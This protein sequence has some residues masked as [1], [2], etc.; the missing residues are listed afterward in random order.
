MNVKWQ[1]KIRD[2]SILDKAGIP[3]I[4]NILMKTQIRWAGHVVRMPGHRLPRLLLYCQIKEGK[5]SQGGQKKRYKDKRK[6][7]LKAFCIKQ[8]TWEDTARNRST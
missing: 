1:E 4:D 2:T 6:I 8:D 7:S 5:H 3:S